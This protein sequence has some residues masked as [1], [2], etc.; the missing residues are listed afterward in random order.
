MSNLKKFGTSIPP[1]RQGLRQA[2]TFTGFCETHDNMIFSPLEDQTY[3]ATNAKQCF[4]VAYRALARELHVKSAAAK[5]GL[6]Q[7][8]LSE[9]L[10]HTG[11]LLQP[12]Q[13]GFVLGML[14]GRGDM[15]SHKADYDNVLVEERYDM[16]AGHV[17]E[18][19][20]PP[21][22]MCCGGVFPEHTFTGQRI[23]R[24]APSPG[25]FSLVCFSAFAS[26]NRGVVVFLLAKG[27][28]W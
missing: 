10:G 6:Q 11:R 17:I 25:R 19:A 24:L 9:G 2:S 8:D 5:H 13:D 7:G 4:L 14:R 26:G 28:L 20:E 21:P 15:R 18:L 23:Q 27:W 1:Q 3:D 22:V 12:R 16:V